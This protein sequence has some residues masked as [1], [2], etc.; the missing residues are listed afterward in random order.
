MNIY[1]TKTSFPSAFSKKWAFCATT[2][3]HSFNL[4]IKTESWFLSR[5]LAWTH[6]I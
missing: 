1:L 4:V 2:S 3:D 5:T 6:V